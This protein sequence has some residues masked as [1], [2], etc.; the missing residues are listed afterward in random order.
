MVLD[1]HDVAHFVVL[2]EAS[3]SIGQHHRL[4]AEQLEDAYGQRDLEQNAPV[5]AGG[6]P[7]VEFC[8]GTTP[9]FWMGYPS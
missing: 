2:V 4:H 7:T 5:L 1:D 6:G 8:G 3:G 9:T